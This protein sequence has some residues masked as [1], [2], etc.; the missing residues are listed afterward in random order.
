MGTHIH[1]IY[2]SGKLTSKYTQ[3]A[4]YCGR[5]KKA[6]SVSGAAFP[7]QGQSVDFQIYII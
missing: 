5:L 4:S 3:S 2:N 6:R 1:K 7:S